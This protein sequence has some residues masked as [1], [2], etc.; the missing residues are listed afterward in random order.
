MKDF[1]EFYEDEYLYKKEEEELDESIVGIAATLGFVTAGL[2][3]AYGAVILISGYKTLAQNAYRALKI[4][5]KK[6]FNKD[7]SISAGDFAKKVRLI[8]R[9]PLVKK[10]EKTL[11]KLEEKYGEKLQEVYKAINDKDLVMAQAKYKETKL[12]NNREIFALLGYYVTKVYGVP[13]LFNDRGN[14]PYKMLKVIIG[15]RAARAISTA[16]MRALSK[17][18]D[19][20]SPEEIDSEA[21]SENQEEKLQEETT[22][23]SKDVLAVK[24]FLD[25][26]KVD[27]SKAKFVNRASYVYA[28]EDGEKIGA[29]RVSNGES[30]RKIVTNLNNSKPKYKESN[31]NQKDLDKV[32]DA[33]I[34]AAQK[35]NGKLTRMKFI[36]RS[37]GYMSIYLRGEKVDEVKVSSKESGLAIQE[38][39]NSERK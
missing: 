26:E 39:L 18:L 38:K 8:E 32:I 27:R 13:P 5:L 22:V 19:I 16:A 33:A 24:K 20:F 9:K 17:H 21:D 2:L 3:S 15:P 25:L 14:E 35:H 23:N 34:K 11:N 37:N 31:I 4:S 36:N 30:A 7:T 29:V 1:K 6:I 12:G 28:Y 10:Q